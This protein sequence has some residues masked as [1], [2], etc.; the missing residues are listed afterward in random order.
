[1][2]KPNLAKALHKLK[3]NQSFLLDAPEK[4]WVVQSGTLALFATKIEA[5]EPTGDRRYLFSVSAGEALFGVASLRREREEGEA[6]SEGRRGGFPVKNWEDGILA[7]TIE[8]SELLELD[9]ADVAA[10]VAALDLEIISLLEGWIDR[11][12]KLIAAFAISSGE[13]KLQVDEAGKNILSN[14]LENATELPQSLALFHSY[15]W[16]QLQKAQQQKVEAELQQFQEL[17][18][19][20]QQVTESALGS[21]ASTFKR[22]Q[23]HFEEGTPLLVAAGA[24]GRAMGITIRPPVRSQTWLR[25][26]PVE[27]IALASQIRIRRVLLAGKWWQTEHGPL[28]AFTQDKRPVA[29]LVDRNKGYRY[30]LFDPEL[31]TRTLVNDAIANSIAPEAY[32]FYR[33]LPSA[34]NKAFDVFQFGVKGYEIDLAKIMFLGSLGTL[35]GMATPQA[36]A[37]LINYAIPNGDRLVL[38]QIVLALLAVSFGQTTLNFSQGLIALRVS[39]GINSILQTAIWDRLLRLSPSLIRQFTIGDLLVRITSITQIYGIVSG[40]TQRTLLSALFSLLNLVLMFVYSIQLTLVALAVTLLA[41]ILSIASSLILLRKERKQEQL[42]GEIQGLVVQLINGVPKLRVGVAEQRAFAAWAKKY[43]EQNQLTW[44]IITISDIV[45]VFN[46]L[47]SLASSILLY[48]FGFAE[49]QSAAAGESGLTLGTFLA[50]NAA[51]GTFFGGV[52]SLSN[53]LT[54]IIQIAPLWERAQPI[55]QGKLESDTHKADP[56]HLQGRVVL[57]KVVF[58]YREEGQLILDRVSI[59][60]EA[61]EF[62]AIVGPSGSGKST[63]FRL[64]LGF[65]TPLSGKI[66]YDGQDLAQLDLQALRRQLG[67]VLQNGRLMQGS[68]FDNITGGALVSM[69]E[70]WQAARMAGFAKD[71]E[72]MPMGMHTV[73]SEG[74]SNLS[75][76]QRQ[77]LAIARSLLLQPRI[78]LLDEA[79]SFLD[80]N[81]QQIVTENL[82][83]LNVTRIVIAHRLSTIR[84]ADRIYVM[85]QGRIVQVGSFAELIQQ[86]GL[87]ARLVARQLEG[88]SLH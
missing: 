45:S 63:I 33:P 59:N 9:I 49:I 15:V 18:Q 67:V 83:K 78:I 16:R 88:S 81:T 62:V 71:I 73:V 64:L 23:S 37:I 32:M 69:N 56:G 12:S 41:A 60:A 68:I 48:W 77:R 28:L 58:R 46:E 55:L 7:V 14:N 70:V 87:F 19:L 39:N 86:P 42:A 84:N 38:L 1:M 61:G 79:T 66:Y 5:K 30:L 35:L 26:D 51:F 4:V 54:Q 82:E 43:S 52:T 53:T 2:L 24:V 3:G 85:E 36:T 50:F 65:E 74:G 13:S 47:L 44:E 57:D 10:E 31:R 22:Q 75:G 6:E 29:L 20:N 80:N 17:E 11:L 21:L 40:A 34:I 8:E 27:E 72:Q 25:R 76:G